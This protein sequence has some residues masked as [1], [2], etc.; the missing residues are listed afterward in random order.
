MADTLCFGVFRLC[1]SVVHTH[2]VP[3]MRPLSRLRGSSGGLIAPSFYPARLVWFFVACGTA[4]AM[5]SVSS[6]NASFSVAALFSE[7][8]S[9][10]PDITQLNPISPVARAKVAN[11]FAAGSLQARGSYM[12]PQALGSTRK[13][14]T[15]SPPPP[16]VWSAPKATHRL[17]FASAPLCGSMLIHTPAARRHTH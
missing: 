1:G 12:S 5:L 8:A 10:H 7:I 11:E 13:K 14:Q 16:P 6:P 2:P 4:V 9:C 3:S 17:V 15:V